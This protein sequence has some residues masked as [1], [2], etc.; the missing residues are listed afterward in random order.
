MPVTIREEVL[1][2]GK[3]KFTF[4]LKQNSGGV[5]VAIV[6]TTGGKSSGICI[7]G[8]GFSAF[9]RWLCTQEI[10]TAEAAAYPRA[11]VDNVRG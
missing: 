11:N 10:H 8:E 2:I 6:E 9:V 5:Y 1:S 3:K 4:K 7:Q